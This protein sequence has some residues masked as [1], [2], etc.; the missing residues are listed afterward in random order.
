MAK[1]TQK[2]PSETPA[3]PKNEKPKDVL[4]ELVAHGRYVLHGPVGGGALFE[5][6]V[7][8]EC[9][10]TQAAGLL[11]HLGEDGRPVFRKYKAPEAVRTTPEG[12]PVARLP[13][14]TSGPVLE[15]GEP[16]AKPTVANLST[17]EED[18]EIAAMVEDG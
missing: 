10:P 9:T 3:A 14:K 1:I 15:E 13:T 7:A 16:V 8:Y 11:A 12:A 18:A 6:G 17:P 2:A 5:R 4:V